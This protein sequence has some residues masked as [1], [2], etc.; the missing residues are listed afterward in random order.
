MAQKPGS[1][2]SSDT[3][4]MAST[5]S[6]VPEPRDQAASKLVDR[7]ALWSGVAGLIPLPVVDVLAVGGLQIQMVRRLSQIYDVEFSENRGKALIA[8]LAGALIPATSGIG[9]AS[10]LKTV[11]VIGTIA[12]GFVMPALSAGATYAIGKAFIQH[13]ATGG[14]L[15]NLNPTDYREFIK[16]QRDMW[17]SRKNRAAKSSPD[18]GATTNP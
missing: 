14:T 5:S 9:A 10:V 1:S 3:E 16:R 2:M 13:F 11:P 4:A 6:D 8:S 15:F 17:D 18:A 7:F 12:G